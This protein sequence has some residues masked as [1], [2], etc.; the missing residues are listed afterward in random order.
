[1]VSAPITLRIASGG[2]MKKSKKR[3][4][5]KLGTPTLHPNLLE[6]VVAGSVEAAIRKKQLATLTTLFEHY[7]LTATHPLRFELLAMALA[8]DHVPAFKIAWADQFKSRGR[9]RKGSDWQA[10][11]AVETARREK[12]N[13]S[14]TAICLAIAKRKGSELAAPS[15]QSAQAHAK[16]LE[17]RYYRHRKQQGG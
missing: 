8:Y 1:M 13:L 5:G 14:V 10:Y 6:V 4:D 7:G 15:G 2:D 11:V 9:P 16:S 17:R 12:L 3:Y